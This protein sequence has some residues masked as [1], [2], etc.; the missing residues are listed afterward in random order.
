MEANIQRTLENNSD[1]LKTRTSILPSMLLLGIA[2]VLGIVLKFI[3][4]SRNESEMPILFITAIMVFVAWGAFS[5]LTRKTIFVHQPSKQKLLFKTI[6]IDI[7]D[8]EKMKQILTDANVTLLKTVR[9][10]EKDAL[11]LHLAYAPDNS[12]FMAQL[13]IY[14]PYEYVNASTVVSLSAEKAAAM[15][16]HFVDEK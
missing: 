15:R 11:Q 12:V 2:A 3:H 14:V 13:S 6:N 8:K 1:F 5:L 4:V 7:N 10:S 16:A 9:K